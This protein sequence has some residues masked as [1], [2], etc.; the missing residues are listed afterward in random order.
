[1]PNTNNAS[2]VRVSQEDVMNGSACVCTNR[3]DYLKTRITIY[4]DISKVM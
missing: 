4:H 1:M 2:Q 3:G